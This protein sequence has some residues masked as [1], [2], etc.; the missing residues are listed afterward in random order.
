MEIEE[1]EPVKKKP[2]PRNLGEMSLQALGE[3]IGELEGEIARVRE[4]ITVKQGAL[5]DAQSVFKK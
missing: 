5:K 4:A 3:Y 2:P 1:F